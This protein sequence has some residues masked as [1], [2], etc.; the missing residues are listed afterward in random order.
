MIELRLLRSFVAVAELEHVGK[1]A[2]RLHISQSPLSRQ[3]RQLEDALG[4]ALFEREKRRIR[5]TAA[6]RDLLAPARDLLARA[7]GLVRD[8][9]ARATGEAGSIAIGFVSSALTS[10]V[11]PAALRTLRRAR[12]KV[13]IA[14]RQ[15]SSREQLG[16]LRA[17]E[18]DLAVVHRPPRTTDLAVHRLLEQPYV[19]AVPR[20]SPL[21]RRP[22]RAARLD[23][24]VWIAVQ[25]GEADR[26]RWA[27]AWGAA[28][29]R[30]DEVV[31]VVEWSSALALVDAGVGVALV[32]ASY[33]ATAPAHVVIRRVPWLAMASPLCLVRRRTAAGPLVDDVTGW[34]L[35]AARAPRRK[36]R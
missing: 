15:A 3:I 36:K 16:A 10:G 2:T 35:D 19:L 11:L 23:G 25:A 31:Q 28:G 4:T 7:D 20:D 32:P 27:A 24:Q 29:L 13:R 17:G 14:L 30:P 22:L 8:A 21:A 18:L 6:G 9:H 5:I 26:D 12:P 34:L 1:A 33:A